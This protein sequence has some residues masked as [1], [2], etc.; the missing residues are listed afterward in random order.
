[1]L[2]VIFKQKTFCGTFSFFVYRYSV[3]LIVCNAFQTIAEWVGQLI[4]KSYDYITII[5]YS[6]YLGI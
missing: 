6:V 1:M 3:G 5:K 4:G 2:N